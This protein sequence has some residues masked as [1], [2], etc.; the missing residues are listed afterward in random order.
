MVRARLRVYRVTKS[1]ARESASSRSTQPSYGVEQSGAT[2]LHVRPRSENHCWLGG[3]GEAIL[4]QTAVDKPM[5]RT[6][7]RQS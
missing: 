2:V 3:V 1:L 4:W 5:S 7:K 6:A